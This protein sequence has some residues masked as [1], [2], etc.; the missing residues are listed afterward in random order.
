MIGRYIDGL[1][2]EERDRIIKAQDWTYRQWDDGDKK[3]L[4]GQ[5]I[6]HR[7]VGHALVSDL[8]LSVARRFDKLVRDWGMTATV[9]LCKMRAAKSNKLKLETSYERV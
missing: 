7:V 5:V 6:D 2:D 3:C 8:E 9:R 4:V 1:T